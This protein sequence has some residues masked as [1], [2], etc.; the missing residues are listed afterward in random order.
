MAVDHARFG[1][2]PSSDLTVKSIL[3]DATLAQLIMH[4]AEHQSERSPSGRAFWNDSELWA[5]LEERTGRRLQRN[6]LAR[7]RGRLV[8]LGLLVAVGQ[9][10]H[11]GVQL[12]HYSLPTIQLHLFDDA[13]NGGGQVIEF[14]SEPRCTEC[15]QRAIHWPGCP[16]APVERKPRERRAT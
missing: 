2:P 5:A 1:D 6:V 9:H 15:G 10:D 4:F 12:E 7:A 13:D 3:M 14:A 16:K 11:L 8:D